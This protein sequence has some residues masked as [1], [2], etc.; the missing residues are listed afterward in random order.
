M[1]DKVCLIALHKETGS[2]GDKSYRVCES[3]SVVHYTLQ[4]VLQDRSLI[5]GQSAIYDIQAKF[6]VT[7]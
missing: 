6:I 2:P 3:E 1:S 7:L 5:L 4:E